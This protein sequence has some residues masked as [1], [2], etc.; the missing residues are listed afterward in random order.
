MRL[1][2]G[3]ALACFFLHSLALPALAGIEPRLQGDWMMESASPQK[4]VFHVMADGRYRTTLGSASLETGKFDAL[5]G[6]WSVRS[7]VGRADTG[8]F[9]LMGDMLILRSSAGITTQWKRVGAGPNPGLQAA[10][11]TSS[12]YPPAQVSTPSSISASGAA[13]S[14]PSLD[15]VMKVA[16]TGATIANAA[17]G[18][19]GGVKTGIAGML[20]AAQQAAAINHSGSS[21]SPGSTNASSLQDQFNKEQ[22]GSLAPATAVNVNPLADETTEYGVASF[23]SR[24]RGPLHITR[25]SIFEREKGITEY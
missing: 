6:K 20:T 10:V 11:S 18:F 1:S 2:T 25:I 14:A 16:Q 9:S 4:T 8:T 17:R 19:R 15:S 3:L 23:E 12:T 13:P 22:L 5:D 7:D 24:A 21:I